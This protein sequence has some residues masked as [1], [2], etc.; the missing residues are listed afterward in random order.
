M[1]TRYA[2]ALQAITVML[3]S[4]SVFSPDAQADLVEA[5][6]ADPS[7]VLRM[8]VKAARAS[9]SREGR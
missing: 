8:R 1:N 5:G 4:G 6:G 9:I 7:E 2:A 3:G